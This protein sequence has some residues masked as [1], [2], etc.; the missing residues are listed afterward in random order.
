[1]DDQDLLGGRYRL[2]RQIGAGGMGVVHEARDLLLGRRVAVKTLAV[3][4][5]LTPSSAAVSRFEQEARALAR[6]NSRH[7][8]KVFDT[9]FQQGMPYLVM[10]L[11]D[12]VELSE[13]T[14]SGSL[15]PAAVRYIAHG[16]CMGLGALHDAGVV[17]RDV[18][19]SNVRITSAH[20]VI[21]QDLGLARL[22]DD[23][24]TITQTGQV[25]G[26]VQYMAPEMIRG[27]RVGPAA[28]LYGLGVCMYQMLTGQRP[29]GSGTGDIGAMVERAVN[30]GVPR[31]LGTPGIPSD[32]AALVDTLTEQDPAKRPRD[33]YAVP[34]RLGAPQLPP[35]L[36]QRVAQR[37][38]DRAVEQVYQA[39]AWASE[40]RSRPEYLD[41]SLRKPD[42]GWVHQESPSRQRPAYTNGSG[43][44]ALSLSQATRTIV[45]GGLSEEQV[46]SRQREAVSLVLSGQFQE[47]VELLTALTRVSMSSWGTEHP[48]TL[49][50][51]Y[52]QAVC[53]ARLGAGAEALTLLSTVNERTDQGRDEER[54][55]S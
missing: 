52:W 44:L 31:L 24:A 10:E 51:Q 35:E 37:I 34:K 4:R 5:P 2:E 38:R 9:G 49:T 20:Q 22:I 48:T 30:E 1:M 18:K 21:L 29:F 12:G 7:V 42:P 36:E 54:A 47:A 8:V 17:H 26:T 45:F 14:M 28:D 13:L 15:T 43:P 53:L 6:I 3:V 33:A 40:A 32:L 19:P 16:M 25:V 46:A 11:L 39:D 50:G 55:R 23:V 41:V 27:A